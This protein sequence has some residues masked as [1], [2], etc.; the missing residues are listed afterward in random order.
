MIEAKN[1]FGEDLI[2]CGTDPITGYFRDGCCNT[3]M[4]DTGTH[5]VCAIM[6]EKF[7]TFTK[8]KGNDLSTPIP[9]YQFPGLK[10]GDHWCLC[11]KRWKEA[12]DVGLAPPVI[13]EA[14]H[15]KSLEVVSMDDLVK[16]AVRKTAK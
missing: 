14:T 4:M 10:S 5:T 3:G 9:R 6:T 8:S 7:L 1:V 13:L 15:E 12:L 16:H 2:V 11:V